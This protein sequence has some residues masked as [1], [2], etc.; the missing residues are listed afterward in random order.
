MTPRQRAFADYYIE[1]GNAAESARRAG[2]SVRTANRIGSENLSKPDIVQYIG[3]RMR[4]Q[5]ADRVASADE[6]LQ[7]LTSCMRGEIAGSDGKALYASER[8]RAAIELLKRYGPQL[9]PSEIPII[10]DDI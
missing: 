8:I 3:E 2:Y 7:F 6:A 10:I 4:E 1:T 9:T 5:V